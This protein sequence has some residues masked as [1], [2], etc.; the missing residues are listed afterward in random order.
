MPYTCTQC[1]EA[2]C[3]Q[4]CPVNAITT[5]ADGVKI[6]H[7]N[8]CVGCKVCTIACPFGTINYNASTGKVIKCDTCLGSPACA[9]AC[10]TGA[11]T[12]KDSEQ[13]GFDKMKVWA[14]QAANAASHEGPNVPAAKG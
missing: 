9:E 11:I 7:E 10:P 12:F 5:N 3:Q 6:V 2:W 1:A 13:A 14:T 8:L 4:A